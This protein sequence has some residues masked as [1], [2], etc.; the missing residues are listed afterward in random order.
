MHTAAHRDWDTTFAALG[1]LR[2]IPTPGGYP[3]IDIDLG[4]CICTEGV[5]T[6][7]VFDCP[8]EDAH[9]R[10]HY[11]NHPP[12]V[13]HMEDVRAKFIQEE[14]LSYHLFLPRVLAYFLHGLFMSPMSWIMRKGKGRLVVDSSTILTIGDLGAPNTSMP[15]PGAE[16]RYYEN[17]PV[18]FGTALTRHLTQI[19]NMRID[20][21]LEDI[22]QHIDDI[23]AA[24]RRLI[25][26]PDLAIVFA[27]VFEEFLIIPVGMIFGSRS[28][29]SFW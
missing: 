7:G 25:Y 29:P 15:R 3:P 22:L 28:S 5:P 2:K 11:D 6:E 23:S 18:Y 8:R 14:L 19:W 1:C 4:H 12:L 13:D 16:G 9:K 20:F 26:H 21:P 17:P 24:F 27:Y 10:I